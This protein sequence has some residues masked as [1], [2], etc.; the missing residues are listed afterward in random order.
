MYITSL[1]TQVRVADLD[2]A[3]LF[4][5]ETLGF[6]EEFRLRNFYAAVRA[7]GTSLH[8]KKVDTIDP[9]IEFVRDGDHLH[10]YVRVI[11]LEETFHELAGKVELV[12]PITTKPWGDREFTIR[13]PDG[14]TI[15]LAQADSEPRSL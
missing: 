5:T 11:D 4:Y 2:R 13:D 10:L 12:Y 14:H 9:S 15:C 6:V 3:L 8:L 1:A 7:G